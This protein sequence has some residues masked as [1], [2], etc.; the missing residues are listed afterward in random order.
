MHAKFVDKWC[1]TFDRLYDELGKDGALAMTKGVLKPEDWY[2]V[3]KHWPVYAAKKEKGL[4]P[5]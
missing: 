3:K 2:Q 4:P 1:Q 5:Q